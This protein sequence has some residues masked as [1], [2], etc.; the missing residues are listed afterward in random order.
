MVNDQLTVSQRHLRF[1][2]SDKPSQSPVIPAGEFYDEN[3]D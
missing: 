2:A 3:V 1:T